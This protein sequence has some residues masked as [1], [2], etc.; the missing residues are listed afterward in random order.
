MAISR[1]FLLALLGVALLGATIFAV[2][3][4]RNRRATARPRRLPSPRSRPRLSRPRRR[5]TGGPEPGAERGLQ[6]ERS[7]QRQLRRPSSRSRWARKRNS[8]RATGAFE[9]DRPEGDAEGRRA[10]EPPTC[11]ASTAAAA[12]SPP[13]T[14]PG[15]HAGTSATRSR[16][17]RGPRSSRPAR[18]GTPPTNKAP[19]LDV[20]PSSLAPERQVRGHRA[21]GRRPGDARL[22]RR[23]LGRA[24][25][26]TS[27]RRSTRPAGS[28][29]APSS[30][31][32]RCVD[33][34]HIDAWVGDDKILRRASLRDVR[35]G[36]RRPA[37]GR[38]PRR[39][40]LA[41]EQAAGRSRRPRR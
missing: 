14:A 17:R 10:G 33:N 30:A 41:G 25:S 28:P 32:R 35:Q 15:S 20:N 39:P 24:R 3:N 8:L 37:R 11:R 18:K 2:Q 26:P 16:R 13:V 27:P 4:A 29:P 6:P 40:P 31:S 7:Q 38:E 36:Q 9:S 12:S 1:P 21:D 19:K 5:S 34:G 22:R 23:E